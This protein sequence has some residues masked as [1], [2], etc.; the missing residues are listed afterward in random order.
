MAII[1]HTLSTQLFDYNKKTKTFV[2]EISDLT[3]KSSSIGRIYDDACDVGFILVSEK[4]GEEVIY[5]FSHYDST[6]DNEVTGVI[7]T[8]INNKVKDAVGTRVLIINN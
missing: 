5:S 1:A 3:F 2:A 8:P 6:P 7:L 4:T